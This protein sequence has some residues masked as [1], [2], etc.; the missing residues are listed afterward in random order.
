[1]QALGHISAYQNTSETTGIRYKRYM[2]EDIVVADVFLGK[3]PVL[4]VSL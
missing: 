3:D 2:N 4:Q 1:M